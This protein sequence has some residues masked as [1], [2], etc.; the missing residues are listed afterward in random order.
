[1]SLR[2]EWAA[3]LQDFEQAAVAALIAALALEAPP[4]V[5][6]SDQVQDRAVVLVRW[7]RRNGALEQTDVFLTQDADGSWVAAQNMSSSS[8]YDT[9]LSRAET[10]WEG[11]DSP[12]LD[13]TEAGWAPGAPAASD[14]LARPTEGWKWVSGM[15]ARQVLGVQVASSLESR[16]RTVDDERGNFVVLIRAGWD[17]ALAVTVRTRSGEELRVQ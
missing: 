5:V 12:V 9:S 1:M 8:A 10:T 17:E 14:V 15:A 7:C 2:G 16:V 4:E 11:W 13:L 3:V 6:V